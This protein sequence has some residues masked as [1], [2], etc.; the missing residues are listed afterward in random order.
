MGRSQHVIVESRS[1]D[2]L[3]IGDH[4]VHQGSLLLYA[5]DDTDNVSDSNPDGR[6]VVVVR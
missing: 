1:S 6:F 2:P 5:D 3:P 4:G